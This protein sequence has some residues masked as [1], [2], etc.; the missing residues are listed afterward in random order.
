M[1]K[2]MWVVRVVTGD[3]EMDTR[4]TTEVAKPG[5]TLKEFMEN[6]RYAGVLRIH[7]DDPSGMCFDIMPP[8]GVDSGTWAEMNAKR[9]RSF[10]YNA[11]KAPASPSPR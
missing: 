3:D 8:I 7:R 11:V 4:S 5:H 1:A 6:L 9:M 2:T 10:G